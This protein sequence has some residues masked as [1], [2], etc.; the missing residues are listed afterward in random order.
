MIMGM[1]C[2]MMMKGVI[3]ASVIY[4]FVCPSEM[5]ISLSSLIHMTSQYRNSIKQSEIKQKKNIMESI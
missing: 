3:Y 5:L 2:K 4:N 1:N